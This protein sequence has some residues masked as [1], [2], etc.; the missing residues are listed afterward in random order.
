MKKIGNFLLYAFV[1]MVILCLTFQSYLLYLDF[2]GR[3]KEIREIK[4]SIESKIDTL[5]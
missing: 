5:K 4:N 2:S 3:H 1:L